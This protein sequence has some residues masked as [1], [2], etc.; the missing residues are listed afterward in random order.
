MSVTSL[1][2]QTELLSSSESDRTLFMVSCTAIYDLKEMLLKCLYILPWCLKFFE[3][4]FLK[5]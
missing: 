4:I 3:I 2:S 5:F 1:R